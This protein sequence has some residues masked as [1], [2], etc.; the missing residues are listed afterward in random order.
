[1]CVFVIC[2]GTFQ[3]PDLEDGEVANVLVD[4]VST[5]GSPEHFFD[6]PKA[7]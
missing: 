7:S 2:I 6:R 5:A 1:M 4:S 3:V